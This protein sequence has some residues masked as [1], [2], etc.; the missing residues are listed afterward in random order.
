MPPTQIKPI[1]TIQPLNQR[2]TG[3]LYMNS[4]GLASSPKVQQTPMNVDIIGN[5][6]PLNIPTT[7]P[8]AYGTPNVTAPLG[9]TTDTNT[10][11][12]TIPPPTSEG[13][14]TNSTFS[15]AMKKF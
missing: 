10:G 14:K 7:T 6:T 15:E 1:S 9:T 3:N 8:I 13:T 11:S 2:P 5:T 12:A 4:N